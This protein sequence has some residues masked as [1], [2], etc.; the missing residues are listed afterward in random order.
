M[1]PHRT[2]LVGLC[3]LVLL[4]GCSDTRANPDA[5][6]S[7][8]VPP[9]K[10]PL[11]NDGTFR[12]PLAFDPGELDPAT[13]VGMGKQFPSFAYDSLVAADGNTVVG[14]LATRW[15]EG[16]KQVVF[17]IRKGVS[18][19]DGS[20]VTPSVI[21]DSF[22]F[23]RSDK[24][25][26]RP[27][28]DV[29]DW[30]VRGDDAAGTVTF[31]FGHPVGFPVQ[32][33]AYV[34]VVCGKGL[35]DRTLLQR[36]TSGSGPY[37]LTRSVP[38]DRYLLERREGY[39]WGPDGASTAETGMPKTIELRVVTDASTA[40]NMLLAG[41]LDGA[42]LPE[43]AHDRLGRRAR[44][45]PVPSE[46]GQLVYNNAGNRVTGDPVV[47]RALT[48]AVDRKAMATVAKG[49]LAD[50]L[51]FP[52]TNPCP[53]PGNRAAIPGHDPAAAAKLLEDAG[54]A[55]GTD[56]T[57][58]K[59]GKRL[60]LDVI[61]ANDFSAEFTAAATL[62]VKAWRE[63]GV[64]AK[65]RTLTGN[66]ML[67]VIVSSEWD[68][69]PMSALGSLNPAQ[70]TGVLAGPEPPKGSNL[71]RIRNPEY[72]R[73]AAQALAAGSAGAACDAWNR[74]ERALYAEGNI[75]PVVAG[76]RYFAMGPHV[77]FG[78]NMAGVV[79]TSIRVHRG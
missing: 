8:G 15:E 44:A 77:D 73:L 11:V 13:N 67:Q 3:V 62:A 22:D 48:M 5:T 64:D 40:V 57:R 37:V 7:G 70:L 16:P 33:L 47:R 53:A 26:D 66:A 54:W 63:I 68:A 69:A 25:Q 2:V 42:G 78:V 4:A 50:N 59:N 27:F 34:P 36:G 49:E 45:I 24:A 20:A 1:F 60:A 65:N 23:Y 17:T 71:A 31:T 21:A 39:T 41:D 32:S 75:F 18:C 12:F 46:L 56:G 28:G 19:S 61:T 51:S 9:A 74:A 14:N 6:A 79:A 35:K 55:K 10:G 58:V 76:N 43:A 38:N 30:R 29:S 52:F 72:D